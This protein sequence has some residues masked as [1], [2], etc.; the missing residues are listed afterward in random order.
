MAGRRPTST[1]ATG[2]GPGYWRYWHHWHRLKIW[3]EIAPVAA[4]VPSARTAIVRTMW[5]ETGARRACGD[6]DRYSPHDLR[7]IGWCLRLGR[8][9]GKCIRRHRRACSGERGREQP[10]LLGAYGVRRTV[11]LNRTTTLSLGSATH[12]TICSRCCARKFDGLETAVNDHS[13]PWPRG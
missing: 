8:G 4:G 12:V 5:F 6:Y 11:P 10:W 2:S 13:L 9:E 7:R 1:R 3:S